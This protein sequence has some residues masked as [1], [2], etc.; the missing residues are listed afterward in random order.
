M[1]CPYCESKMRYLKTSQ[2]QLGKY[3]FLLGSLE[4]I[5]AGAVPSH[6]YVCP[7]CGKAFTVQSNKKQK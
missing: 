7:T 5:F 2:I 4:H 3:G 6:I 1:K